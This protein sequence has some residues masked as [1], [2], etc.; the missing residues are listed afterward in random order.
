[1]LSNAGK[2]PNKNKSIINKVWTIFKPR[3][4]WVAATYTKPQGSKPLA[5][6][7]MKNLR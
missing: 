2:V 5:N 6:P 4:D 1:M 7:M 3:I